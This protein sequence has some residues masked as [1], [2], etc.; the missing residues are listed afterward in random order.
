[1]TNWKQTERKNEEKNC[2]IK[3]CEC[4]CYVACVCAIVCVS[5]CS[6]LGFLG[7]QAHWNILWMKTIDYIPQAT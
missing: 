3:M 2:V 7:S 4:M 6:L 1:M 5:L